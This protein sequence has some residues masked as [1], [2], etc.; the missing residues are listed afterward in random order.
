MAWKHRV[1]S[2]LFEKTAFTTT[3][4]REKK[5]SVRSAKD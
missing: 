3:L 2:G 4:E 1:G 5:E